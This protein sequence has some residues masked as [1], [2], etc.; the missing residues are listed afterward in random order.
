MASYQSYVHLVRPPHASPLPGGGGLIRIKMAYN[1]EAAAGGGGDPILQYATERFDHRRILASYE[2]AFAFVSG[3]LVHHFGL[4]PAQTHREL[5]HRLVRGALNSASVLPDARAG[6]FVSVDL[7]TVYFDDNRGDSGGPVG[8][9]ENDVRILKS[10]KW[11]GG[12]CEEEFCAVC[13]AELVGGEVIIRLE[14][15][16]SHVFHKDCILVWLRKNQTCPLCRRV[17]VVVGNNN[18]NLRDD[19]ERSSA[20]PLL[21]HLL[22]G[23]RS[24]SPP[25]DF[26]SFLPHNLYRSGGPV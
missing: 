14:P 18:N 26:A 10:E 16:C 22:Y 5:T 20:F 12:S 7:E 4:D 11:E 25:V 21:P 13:L 24:P 9:S 19:D 23:R 15:C 17:V 1:S 2:D 3:V 8:L 6:V